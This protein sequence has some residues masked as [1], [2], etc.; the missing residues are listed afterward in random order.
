MSNSETRPIKDYGNPLQPEFSGNTYPFSYKPHPDPGSL[1]A[2]A[3]APRA[4]E[5]VQIWAMHGPPRHRLDVTNVPRLTGCVAQAEKIASAKPVLCVFGHFHYS[6]G[7]ERVSWQG[8]GDAV[9]RAEFMTLSKER[10]E[11]E[12]L[13]GPETCFAFDF[14]GNGDCEKIDAEETV[15]VNAAWMTMKKRHVTERNHPIAITLAL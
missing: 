13:D 1:A 4:S 3:S 7:V 14:S 8:Q 9:A 2:W 5:G 10:K 12:N 6:W 15:F 11:E